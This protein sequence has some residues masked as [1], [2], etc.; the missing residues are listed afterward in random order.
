MTID[1]TRPAG[2]R[3]TELLI[4]QTGSCGTP[5]YGPV[6]DDQMYN[7]AM[8]NYLANG[9]DGFSMIAQQ[10]TRHLFG[11]FCTLCIVL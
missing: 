3:I 1:V 5:I 2:Q 9:G 4:K 7:I 11:N 10:K 8:I 6:I